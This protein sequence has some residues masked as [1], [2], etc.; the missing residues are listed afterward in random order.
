LVHFHFI[1]EL[2]VVFLDILQFYVCLLLTRQLVLKL[3]FQSRMLTLLRLQILLC[4]SHTLLHLL[5]LL[6]KA[7][8]LLLKLCLSYFTQLK[9][10]TG[11]SKL[12]LCQLHF[13]LSGFVLDDSLIFVFDKSLNRLVKFLV[14]LLCF[15]N[16]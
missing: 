3:H 11:L 5:K 12:R 4:P 7:L 8:V 6:L 1:V 16:S 13:L 9:G 2:L 15:F 14:L 10:V